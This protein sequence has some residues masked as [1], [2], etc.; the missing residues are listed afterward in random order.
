MLTP[1]VNS[2]LLA[3][4]LE[5]AGPKINMLTSTL[6]GISADIRA[7]ERWLLEVGVRF[8]V[9]EF[10]EKESCPDD[11]GCGESYRYL[12]WYGGESEK[13]WRIYYRDKWAIHR[14][15]RDNNDEL[16]QWMDAGQDERP[17]IETQIS[18]R[19][20][21]DG[22]LARLVSAVAARIPERRLVPYQLSLF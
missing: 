21:C 4:A 3:Q 6:D 15:E 1:Q 7:V 14:T 2:D 10:I 20:K 17:L 13:S 19:L 9:S 18:V 16:Y 22:P 11:V 12:V 8:E 5:T